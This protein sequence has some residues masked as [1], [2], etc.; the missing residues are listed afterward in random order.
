M[1]KQDLTA[2]QAEALRGSIRKWEKIVKG[3]GKDKGFKNCPLCEL[4]VSPYD[5]D[6]PDNSLYDCH[7]CPVMAVTNVQYCVNT[8]YVKWRSTAR[9][10][11]RRRDAKPMLT[12]LQSI[13]DAAYVRK[14]RGGA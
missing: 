4:Y 3:T 6:D 14:P 2:R 10:I 9:F 7:G 1:K 12:F 8:P 11:N 5:P 13:L